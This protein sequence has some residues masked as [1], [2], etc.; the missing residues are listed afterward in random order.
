MPVTSICRHHLLYPVQDCELKNQTQLDAIE[1]E[2]GDRIPTLC[3]STKTHRQLARRHNRTKL[4][5]QRS[6]PLAGEQLPSHAG[7]LFQ[8][9]SRSSSVPHQCILA[10]GSQRGTGQSIWRQFLWPY[11]ASATQE[12]LKVGLYIPWGRKETHPF[13]APQNPACEHTKTHTNFIARGNGS[14]TEMGAGFAP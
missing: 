10:V 12:T 2:T 14:V 3:I 6:S 4:L 7:S 9:N 8:P 1:A 13:T 5:T 11:S